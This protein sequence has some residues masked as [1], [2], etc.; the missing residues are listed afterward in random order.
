MDVNYLWHNGSEKDWLA[1][2]D[3]YS[4]HIRISKQRQI[5]KEFL[6][7]KSSDIRQMKPNEFYLFLKEKYF[8]WKYTSYLPKRLKEL[9]FHQTDSGLVVLGQ[10]HKELFNE[11]D[12]GKDDILRLIKIAQQIHGLGSAGASGLITIIFP[13]KFGTVDQYVVKA[14][15][16]LHNFPFHNELLMMEP[17]N[18][19]AEDARIIIDIYRKKAEELNKKFNS[20][21]WTPRKIDQVLWCVGR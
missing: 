1:A 9:S 5:D 20:D 19:C 21:F 3:E 4:K 6:N 11:F 12:N 13:E 7:L 16:K 2:L 10:I 8:V 14:L 18:L 17:E 15:L